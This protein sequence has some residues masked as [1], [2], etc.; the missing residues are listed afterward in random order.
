MGCLEMNQ[1][2]RNGGKCGDGVLAGR[3]GRRERAA[4]KV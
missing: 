1:W 2:I 4:A 3:R